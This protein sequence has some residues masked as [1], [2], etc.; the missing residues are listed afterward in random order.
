MKNTLHIAAAG[1][2]A[3]LLTG[4]PTVSPEGAQLGA[5]VNDAMAPTATVMYDQVV[6]IDKVL[7][8]TKNGKI[9]M[10]YSAMQP[11]E[12]VSNSLAALQALKKG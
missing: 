12:H 11:G 9:A 1:M 6:I 8:N 3:L 10:V 5:R 7:Q 4:C 2:A